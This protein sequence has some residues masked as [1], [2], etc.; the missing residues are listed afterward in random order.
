VPDN[1]F[2]VLPECAEI[3]ISSGLKRRMLLHC[4]FLKTGLTHNAKSSIVGGRSV[5]VRGQVIKCIGFRGRHRPA[6][7]WDWSLPCSQ[8]SWVVYWTVHQ[9][10]ILHGSLDDLQLHSRCSVTSPHKTT[11]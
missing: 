2:C 8:A 3:E 5:I 6:G 9:C 1:R 4:T 11:S 10:I 7:R